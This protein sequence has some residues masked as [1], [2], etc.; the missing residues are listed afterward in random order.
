MHAELKIEIINLIDGAFD[1]KIGEYMNASS[2]GQYQA[3]ID[4]ILQEG[5][6]KVLD[7]ISEFSSTSLNAGLTSILD[8]Y[9]A[10]INQKV[11]EVYQKIDVIFQSQLPAAFNLKFHEVLNRLEQCDV[12]SRELVIKMD[13]FTMNKFVEVVQDAELK[14][15]YIQSGAT[16][17]DVMDG[18]RVEKTHAYRLINGEAK[19]L[20]AR[21]KLKQFLLKKIKESQKNYGG[22]K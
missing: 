20:E 11:N 4:S 5:K 7:K 10:E 2:N 18:M 15:L 19:D 9:I 3:A 8:T 12:R 22:K 13:D 1:R 16:I 6:K 14:E 21:H 17:Q